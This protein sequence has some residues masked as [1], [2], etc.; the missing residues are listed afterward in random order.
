V[1]IA[2][3]IRRDPRRPKGHAGADGGVEH[4]VRH[5]RY[6]ARLDLEMH[7]AAASALF[8]IVGSDQPAVKWM[9]GVVNFNFMPDMGR[10]TA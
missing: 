10:M 8:A 3:G 6:Y 9:P 5:Y 2:Q 1:Q 7:D 4:P